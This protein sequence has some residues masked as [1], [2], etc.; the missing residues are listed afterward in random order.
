[1]MDSTTTSYNL[2]Q[3][4]ITQGHP[5]GIG[6]GWP[7]IIVPFAVAPCSQARLGWRPSPHGLE[8]Y[9][10]QAL[11]CPPHIKILFHFIFYLDHRFFLATK[12]LD[13][14]SYFYC[15]HSFFSTFSAGTWVDGVVAGTTKNS[16]HDWTASTWGDHKNQK[17]IWWWCNG[18]HSQSISTPKI[19]ALSQTTGEVKLHL[20]NGG[21][22][23]A[24]YTFK[25][26]RIYCT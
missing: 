24:G 6:P 26:D 7:V 8:T 9:T 13:P 21:W 18:E 19:Q 15:S 2:T 3:P 5:S 10:L 17:H 20:M 23:N 22:P 16:K 11:R 14:Y 1:M 25:L 12:L 4:F